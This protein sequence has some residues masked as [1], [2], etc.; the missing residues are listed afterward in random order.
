MYK[1][2]FIVSI[3]LLCNVSCNDDNMPEP[4][5]DTTAYIKIQQNLFKGATMIDEDNLEN[6]QVINTIAL[7]LTEPSS[8]EITY[9]YIN[10]GSVNVDGYRLIALPLQLSELQKKDV[11]LITNY[12]DI[13]LSVVNTMDDINELTTPAVD[14]N[15][16]L[17]PNEGFCMYGELLN[18]DF[19]DENS[20]AI[21]NLERTCAKY[22][23]TLTFPDNPVLSMDN[24]FVIANEASYTHIVNDLRT[25]IPDS[26]YFN[27]ADPIILESD[28]SGKY[29]NTVYMYEAEK[30]PKIYIYTRINN[31]SQKQ[32]FSTELPVPYR[33]FIYDIDI[34]IYENK[35]SG[36]TRLG[37]IEPQ[38][39][40]KTIVRILHK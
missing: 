31:S 33:N 36:T 12:K 35:D 8:Q 13:N 1:L 30:A 9:K 15:H 18:Y 27:I 34:Q 20:S 38:Y 14:K 29:I 19:T 11:Y 16:D 5:V 7:F 6:E 10:I 28:G 25:G 32:E 4:D 39:R 26:D 17:D 3:I 40:M 21:V 22:R 2:I 23:V 24:T 37:G